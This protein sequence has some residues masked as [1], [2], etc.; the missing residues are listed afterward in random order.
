M[1]SIADAVRQLPKQLYRAE[2]VRAMDRYA[3]ETLGVPGFV[4][5][6]NAGETAYQLIRETWP[7]GCRLGIVCGA[8]NNGGDGYVAANKALDSAMDVR[9]FGLAPLGRLRGDALTAAESFVE[10]GGTV[11]EFTSGCLADRDIVVDGLLGTGLDRQ[12]TGSYADVINEINHFSGKVLALDIPSGLH[13]DTGCP[14]GKAVQAEKTITFIGLKQGLFTGEAADHCGEIHYSPLGVS[15]S[16][17]AGQKPSAIL[18]HQEDIKFSQRKH[19][20][21]K[22]N[23]GHVLV[24][25]GDFGYSGAIRLAGEAA[26]RVGAGLVSIATRPEHAAFMNLNRPEL[27]CHGVT[28]GEDVR[29]LL[30]KASVVAIGPGLGQ[31][32]WA[33]E[34]LQTVIASAAPLVI[35]ADALNLLAGSPQKHSRW[36]L[37]PHP[38]EAAR[39]LECSIGEVQKDRF[40]AVTELMNKFGGVC[41]LKGPGTLIAMEGSPIAVNPTGNPGMATGGMGDVLTGII[42]GLI[43]QGFGLGVAAKMGAWLHGAAADEASLQGERGLLPSDLFTPLRRLVDQ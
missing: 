32:S 21:H 7:T 13:A 18:I 9:L 11:E 26:A 39:L 5:M 24:I 31:S 16:V 38:G 37:T 22:G 27:M 4:L 8:G 42:A 12:V 6:A 10:A 36:V 1:T 33:K 29:R 30:G 35:D 19:C 34:I 43:A 41:L 2:Q 20:A 15:D 14:M 28:T 3:I 17:S 25:G 23:F 40:K